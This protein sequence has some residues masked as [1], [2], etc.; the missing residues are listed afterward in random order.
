[1]SKRV[2]KKRT[3]K[4]RIKETS[5]YIY[6]K[7]YFPKITSSTKAVSERARQPNPSAAVDSK[8]VPTTE[9]IPPR[10]L[11]NTS[12]PGYLEWSSTRLDKNQQTSVS[13]YM[14]NNK[15]VHTLELLCICR[16]RIMRIY[17]LS[18]HALVETDKPMEEVVACGIII[19]SSLIVREVILKR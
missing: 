14:K 1:M 11:S 7:V 9:F 8:N 3:R 17:L 4:E 19:G 10:A 15:R 16:T 13:H 18:C 5:I 2:I 12:E 6:V